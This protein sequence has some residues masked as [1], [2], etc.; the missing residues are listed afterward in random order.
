MPLLWV[1]PIFVEF[2]DE[3]CELTDLSLNDPRTEQF[4]IGD[5]RFM[6]STWM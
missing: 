4:Y 3:V 2:P 6:V 1:C 5:V